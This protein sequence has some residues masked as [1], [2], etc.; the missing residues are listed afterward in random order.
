LFYFKEGAN[1]EYQLTIP[2]GSYRLELIKKEL[3]PSTN[4]TPTTESVKSMPTKSIWKH[5]P[6]FICLS[7]LVLS[8]GYIA[9]LK[10][11]EG[12]KEPFSNSLL[13]LLMSESETIDIV[14]GSKNMYREYDSDMDLFRYI[15]DVNYIGDFSQIE[16]MQSRFPQKK[17]TDNGMAYHINFEAMRMVSFIELYCKVN[18]IKSN[19]LRSNMVE[20]FKHNAVVICKY[21]EGTLSKFSKYFSGSRFVA[22]TYGESNKIHQITH[23]KQDD[24]ILLPLFGKKSKRSKSSPSYFI[25]KKVKTDNEKEVIFFLSGNKVTQ[26]FIRYN[27]FSSSFQEDILEAFEGEVPES[28]ELLIEL[29][30]VQLYEGNCK[31]IYNSF[32]DEAS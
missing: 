2:K 4:T 15:Y 3:P 20:R 8:L 1:E 7:L 26:D 16:E 19:I 9:Y 17:I 21:T 5:Y 12:H 22:T 31:I 28:F 18:G 14:V 10:I 13:S 24:N 27:L 25:I 32:L 6:L 29:T 30:N 23:F 11:G